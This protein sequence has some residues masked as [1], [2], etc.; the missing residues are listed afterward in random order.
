VSYERVFRLPP[1]VSAEEWKEGHWPEAL[2]ARLEV[3]TSRESASN[4]RRFSRRLS[5]FMTVVGLVTLFLGALGVA[6]G[7]HTFMAGKLDHA[8]VL[9][10]LGASSRDVFAVYGLLVARVGLL[11]SGIG[12]LAG[13]LLLPALGSAASRLG[14]GFLPAELQ[15]AASPTAVLHGLGAGLISSFAFALLPVFRMAAVPPLRVLGRLADA[16]QSPGARRVAPL[17]AGVAL[18]AVFGLS[19]TQADSPAVGLFFTLA[20]GA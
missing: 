3:Q 9:R 6:S 2:A 20:I 13:V 14:S 5:G 16:P 19:A 8:A 12:A 15:L 17:A 11:G 18:L 4:V 1:D 7:M 10:C